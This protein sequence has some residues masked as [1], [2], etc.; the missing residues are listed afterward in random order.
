[1]GQPGPHLFLP[2]HKLKTT[3]LAIFRAALTAARLQ[4]RQD[5]TLSPRLECSGTIVTHYSLILPSSSCPPISAFRVAGTTDVP[6]YLG[7]SNAAWLL[8]PL[9]ELLLIK[10]R[11]RLTHNRHFFQYRSERFRKINSS[12][13]EPTWKSAESWS[14]E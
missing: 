2:L 11:E 9:A 1:M 4:G 12:G 5:L 3:N 6:P 13:R 10:G 7:F 14:S 8:S